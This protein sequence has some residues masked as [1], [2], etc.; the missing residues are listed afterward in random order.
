M[1]RR[2]GFALQADAQA[3]TDAELSRRRCRCGGP[4]SLYLLSILVTGDGTPWQ[5]AAAAAA[6]E[7]V[8]TLPL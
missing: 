6:S 3:N 7:Q 2:R 4:A 1:G 5:I 8:L